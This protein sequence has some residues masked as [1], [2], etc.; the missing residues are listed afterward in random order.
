MLIDVVMPD[1]DGYQLA[2]QVSKC[3]PNIKI[4]MASGFTDQYQINSADKILH[5]QR[6]QKPFTSSKLLNRIRLLLDETG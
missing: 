1:T 3:Y 6:L 4:Q 5:K 2:A